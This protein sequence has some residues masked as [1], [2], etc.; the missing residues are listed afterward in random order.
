[1]KQSR[2]VRNHSGACDT[3]TPSFLCL[4][5]NEYKVSLHVEIKKLPG[6]L[7]MNK[8]NFCTTFLSEGMIKQRQ[9]K[10]LNSADHL[11][12]FVTWWCKLVVFI[13]KPGSWQFEYIWIFHFN[14]T[15][16][17]CWCCA[18]CHVW[19]GV[20]TCLGWLNT[21]TWYTAPLCPQQCH[22]AVH[23][24]I[25]VVVFS[26]YP[27]GIRNN[28]LYPAPW[29]WTMIPVLYSRWP[30]GVIKIS[31][32]PFLGDWRCTA[33]PC[34]ICHLTVAEGS[35]DSCIVPVIL[36]MDSDN[37]SSTWYDDLSGYSPF[38]VRRVVE[39][40]WALVSKHTDTFVVTC[41][42]PCKVRSKKNG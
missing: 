26:P 37:F 30:G 27:L 8:E 16:M 39:H 2:N 11:F 20:W 42:E 3:L 24:I 13:I 1:M 33:L 28:V 41:Y 4:W 34:R 5:T 14:I 7:N 12:F 38:V 21:L 17:N 23:L 10:I 22:S 32:G 35:Q 19:V 40:K 15:W 25:Y 29:C 6:S 31:R 9:S 36:C 18:W